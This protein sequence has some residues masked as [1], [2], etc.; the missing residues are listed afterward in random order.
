MLFYNSGMTNTVLRA[1]SCDTGADP[2]KGDCMIAG[3]CGWMRASDSGSSAKIINCFAHFAPGG[4]ILDL[5]MASASA[6]GVF[7]YTSLSAAGTIEVANFVTNLG[8]SDLLV[9]GAPVASP[10]K[11]YGALY[12]ML[13]DRNISV[14]KSY[15]VTGLPMCGQ[16]GE[17]VVI[18]DNEAVAPGELASVQPKLNAFASAYTDYALKAWKVVDGLPVL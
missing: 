6:G 3:I 13:P 8:A 4:M 5:P 14:K 9:A 15:C 1:T 12:G 7:G 16:T 11:R 18:A 17:S 2:A 10:C